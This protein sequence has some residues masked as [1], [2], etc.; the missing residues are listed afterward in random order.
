MLLMS[1]HNVCFHGEIF[2]KYFLFLHENIC[3]GYSSISTRCF[4][5]V[6]TTYVFME[7]YF[8]NI[9]Y[10]SMKTYV[11]GTQASQQGA[12]DEYPQHMFS[13]RNKGEMLLMSTHNI[14]FHGEIRKEVLLMSTHNICFH[15]GTRKNITI[16]GY[17][18]Y[19]ELWMNL[20]LT[21][22]IKKKIRKIISVLFVWI[23]V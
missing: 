8:L 21:T 18:S 4:W 2:L 5:W 13:W 1:T 20:V 10:F 23:L 11:V 19:L 14:C 17:P 15:G 6:P 9:S 3:C 22:K 7:K 16:S 12:S